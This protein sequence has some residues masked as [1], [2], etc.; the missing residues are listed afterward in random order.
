M[1]RAGVARPR[2]RARK[3]SAYPY[4]FYL[5]AFAVFFVFFLLPTFSSSTT[6]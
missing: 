6:D 2:S 3:K 5:P 4:W 1:P